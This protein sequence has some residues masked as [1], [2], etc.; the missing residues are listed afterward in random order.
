MD[1]SLG[2]FSVALDRTPPEAPVVPFGV[3][4]GDPGKRGRDRIG[5]SVELP[6][7]VP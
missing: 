3:R 7:I 6:D 1:P 5:E 4:P 2:L